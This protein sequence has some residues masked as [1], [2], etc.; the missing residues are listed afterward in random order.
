MR[1]IQANDGKFTLL[2]LKKCNIAEFIRV[3]IPCAY[4]ANTLDDP[5]VISSKAE[6]ITITSSE[7][8]LLNLDGEY[9]GVLPATFENLY[10]HI[11][12]FAPVDELREAGS[13]LS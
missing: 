7:E 8:V 12:M 5:L 3:V 13:D 6:K 4:V 9:G 1:R 11:E 2:I 10:R